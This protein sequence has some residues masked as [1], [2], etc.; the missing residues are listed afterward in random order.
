[1][2]GRKPYRGSS[3]KKSVHDVPRVTPGPPVHAM[4]PQ[5]YSE[6]LSQSPL[7]S[8]FVMPVHRL[9]SILQNYSSGFQL[10]KPTY[11]DIFCCSLNLIS[12]R[13][14]QAILQK[15]VLCPI[16]LHH[17]P[18][19]TPRHSESS[20]CGSPTAYAGMPYQG[21]THSPYNSPPPTSPARMRDAYYH[22]SSPVSL[23]K[24]GCF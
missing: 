16:T 15:S 24:V 3:N 20:S 7:E 22:E 18:R 12:Y 1:M 2:Q 8:G 21:P 9:A 14:Q 6:H 4:H 17:S 11:S 19:R 23:N 10:P 5:Q 13:Y